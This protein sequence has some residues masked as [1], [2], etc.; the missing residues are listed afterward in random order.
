AMFR[1]RLTTFASAAAAASSSPSSLMLRRTLL[2]TASLRGPWSDPLPSSSSSS[3]PLKHYIILAEDVTENGEGLRRRLSVRSQ[4][5]ADAREGKESGRIELGGGLLGVDHA[6]VGKD[7]PAQHLKGSLF[8]VLGE[9]I[10]DVRS[11]LEQ[12]VYF[13][14]GAFDPSKIRIF[15]FLK[16]SLGSSPAGA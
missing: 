15:P 1:P 8:V 13:S 11:R 6:E 7:G 12:D 2:T 4:H 9:S 16:A 14:S 5:L 3:T 10:A